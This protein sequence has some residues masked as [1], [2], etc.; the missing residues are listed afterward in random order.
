ML[1]SKNLA[2]VVEVIEKAVAILGWVDTE[3]NNR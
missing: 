1:S 3:I 2:D